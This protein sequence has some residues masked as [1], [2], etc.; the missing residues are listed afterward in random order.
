MEHQL[1]FSRS[2]KRKVPTLHTS[3]TNSYLIRY[4]TVTDSKVLNLKTDGNSVSITTDIM[5]KRQTA[6]DENKA[7]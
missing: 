6:I 5:L 7:V 3:Q 4:M 2:E 1:S